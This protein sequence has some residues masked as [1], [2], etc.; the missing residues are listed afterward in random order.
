MIFGS[1]CIA[2]S[3]IFTKLSGIPGLSSAFYRVVI[4]FMIYL[5]FVLYHRYYIIDRSRIILAL[6]CGMIFAMDL[7]CWNQSLMITNTAVATVLGNL[8]PI[9]AGILLFLFT[10]Y[11]PSGYYWVGVFIAVSGLIIMLGWS[12]VSHFNFD[13]GSVLA[14]AASLCYACYMILTGK[15]RVGTSNSSF[16]FYSMMGYMISAFIFALVFHSPLHGFTLKAWIYLLLLAVVPQLLGWL[17]VNHALGALPS[18]EVSMVLLGQIVIAS[19]LAVLIFKESLSW[20]QITGGL[21]IITGIA[22]TYIKRGRI[23]Q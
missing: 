19:L 22:V 5:P 9:W 18:T 21:V 8:S 10:D 15:A 16:M 23:V 6:F 7:G 11:K 13:H 3:P 1:V 12:V 14:L 17:S 4:A 2:F 20:S